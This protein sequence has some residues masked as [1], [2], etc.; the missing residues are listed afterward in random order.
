MNAVIVLTCIF[1]SYY[2]RNRLEEREEQE[3]KRSLPP[4]GLYT[5]YLKKLLKEY[6]QLKIAQESKKH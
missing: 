4:K 3:A 5:E 6:E 2:L 1:L